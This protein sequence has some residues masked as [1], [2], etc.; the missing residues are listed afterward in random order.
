MNEKA[1]APVSTSAMPATA[2]FGDSAVAVRRIPNAS[3]AAIRY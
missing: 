1:A 3:A 2:A